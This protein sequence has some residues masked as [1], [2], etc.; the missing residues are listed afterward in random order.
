MRLKVAVQ[1]VR[2][3]QLRRNLVLQL[4]LVR[5]LKKQLPASINTTYTTITYHDVLQAGVALWVAQKLLHQLEIKA[6]WD[7]IVLQHVAQVVVV[8]AQQHLRV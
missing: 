5:G 7:Q 1:V 3:A 6:L 8:A 2:H 4:N